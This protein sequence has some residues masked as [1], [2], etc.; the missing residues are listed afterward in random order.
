MSTSR[1]RLFAASSVL[2]LALCASACGGGTDVCQAVDCGAQ[3]SCVVDQGRA[4]CR[5]GY[6]PDGLSC[7]VDPC[8]G[9][10]C[11]HGTCTPSGSVALCACEPGYADARCQSCAPGYHVEGLACV[12][13]SPCAEDP[14]VYGTCQSVGG[15]ATC[16]CAVG[17]AGVHCDECAPGYH[18]QDLRCVGESPC[19]P[20]PCVHGVCAAVDGG[21]AC[22]C[23]SG[24]TGPWCEVC[25][26]GWHEEGLVCVPDVGGPCDPNPCTA[27][28]Q[29]ICAVDG[30]GYTCACDPGYHDAGGACAADTVCAPNPCALA[31]QTT[32][33]E[34][35]ATTY[36][37]HCDAGFHDDGSG[38][39]VADTACAPNP[40]TTVHRTACAPDGAGGHTCACDS[41][42][43]DDGAGG[44]AAITPCSPNP[45]AA[46]NQTQCT[47]N[48]AGF[49]CGC[50]PGFHDAAGTGVVDTV[51][52][53]ATTCAGHGTCT[54]AGLACQCAAGYTGAHCT[55]CDTG[56][57][58]A[59][60]GC[61]ADSVC[62]PNP[63]TTVHKTVCTS[64]GG[65]AGCGCD[66]GYQDQDGDGT[67]TAD[68][69]TAGLACGARGHCAIAAGTAGCACDTGYAGAG[70]DA[71]AGGYQD[72]DHNGTCLATCATAN[73][74]CGAL[75][76]SDA[77]GTA[78][79]AG[80]RSC[81]TA[82]TY[83]PAGQTITALYARGEF[84]AWGL[85][86]PLTRGADGKWKASVNLAAGD[87][88]Y[89]LYDQGRD[90]W[91]EDPANPYFKWVTNRRNSRLR[92]P[93][94]NQPLLVLVSQP[95]VVA[96]T[97]AVSFQV[98]Y[99]DGAAGAGV[100]A[101]TATVT[102]NG[103]ALTAAFNPATGVFTV[104]DTGLARGKYAYVFGASDA[105]AR[106]AERLYV[107]VWV[108]DAPFAWQDAI[109]YFAL[110][111]RFK[112]GDAANN[113]PVSGVDARANWQGGDFAGLKSV[114]ESGYFD[115]LGVNTLWVSSPVWNTSG[116]GVGA[117]GR[118]YSGYH[119]Y[120]GSWA[121]MS[122]FLG[123]H[124]VPR[125][126]SHA[127]GQIADMWGNN[128]KEQGWNSPPAL[129]T[130]P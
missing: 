116:S 46:A 15:Q 115:T 125:A 11:V 35:G 98:Q 127:A 70:C 81:A 72:N 82:I 26:A 38:A 10:P 4:A 17:Y 68:C 22:A 75:S 29:T 119:S 107:P 110:T 92:V 85:T 128:A 73:L 16:A 78:T 63:C 49:V 48:G 3:G 1:R 24:Y 40:C 118:L 60:G 53:P 42:Y 100:D 50:D 124:D 62:D 109:M 30:A 33:V 83:D 18:P 43:H 9:S 123:N 77:S 113:A 114:I 87:Y 57:H 52:D 79:C 21:A 76:C 97:G 71:C 122:T 2:L 69:N 54:G 20:D 55:A 12:A 13:G 84:N 74:S 25:A 130:A 112:D 19:D 32:C 101:A 94:C 37:C 90:Q 96:A 39:C 34:T 89:K 93:D 111:D 126:L 7:I 64:S 47:V 108:E 56:Y 28:H 14:C 67:C 23:D 31:H 105:A 36:A 66:P 106:K 117:D 103:A 58:A 41:G 51:C 104:S 65:S 5:A 8:T 120:Y 45:C 99:V 129:P 80:T 91:F 27:A 88:A 95:A 59:G 6:V 44:C 102:R 121:V 61:V 86:T